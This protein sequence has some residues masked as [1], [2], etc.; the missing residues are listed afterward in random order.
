MAERLPI[1]AATSTGST[2]RRCWRRR[3][4]CSTSA[5]AARTWASPGTSS[6]ETNHEVRQRWPS[7]SA[8]I[9]KSALLNEAAADRLDVGLALQQGFRAGTD[10]LVAQ[11]PPLV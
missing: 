5:P 11:H 1:S 7:G 10:A 3:S 4:A 6:G 2:G 8:S 9:G